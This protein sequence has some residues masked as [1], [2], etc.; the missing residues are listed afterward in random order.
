MSLILDALNRSR[1][2]ADRVPGLGTQH[3]DES[4]TAKPRDWRRWLPWIALAVAVLVIAWLLLERREDRSLDKPAAVPPAVE[5]PGGAMAPQA[6]ERRRPV[7][8]PPPA[9]GPQ[10]V[11]RMEPVST[12][13]PAPAPA[14]EDPAEPPPVAE[15]ESPSQPVAGP[16]PLEKPASSDPAVTALY[17]RRESQLPAAPVPAREVA[18]ATAPKPAPAEKEREEQ[19]VDIEALVTQAREEIDNARLA[20]HS[21]PFLVE[22]SQQT[23]D[24][25]PTILYQRHN[26]RGDSQSSTVVLNG[27]ELRVGGRPAPGVK[28]EEILP[29]SVVLSYQGT[30]FRLRALNSWVNL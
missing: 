3:F 14:V 6:G 9:S 7:P 22:L 27:E 19:P 2:D 24:S 18:P 11:Q 17:Q 4:V 12:A 15:P 16:V 8:A 13:P 23:K 29:D 21:A 26:Y 30:Q 1:Q 10:P 28:V 5:R 25:I 20:E